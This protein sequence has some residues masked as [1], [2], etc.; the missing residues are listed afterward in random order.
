M[1]VQK[2]KNFPVFPSQFYLIIYNDLQ[3]KNRKWIYYKYKFTEK[4]VKIFLLNP[5]K[6]SW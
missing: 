1:L 3:K 6:T 2:C 5:T 4:F